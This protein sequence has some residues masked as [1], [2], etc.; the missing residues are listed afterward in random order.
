M[1]RHKDEQNKSFKQV[2]QQKKVL[3]MFKVIGDMVYIYNSARVP[4]LHGYMIAG[5]TIEQY[6]MKHNIIGDL[7]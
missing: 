3:N 4:T 6:L 1:L 7:I 2:N 5:E